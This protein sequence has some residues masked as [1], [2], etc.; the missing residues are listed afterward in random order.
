MMLN[1]F[2]LQTFT[3]IDGLLKTYISGG[4]TA[5]M[6]YVR[7]PLGAAIILYIMILGIMIQTGQVKMNGQNFFKS[8]FKIALIYMFATNWGLFSQFFVDGFTQLAGGVSDAI[9]AANPIKIP[10]IDG[11]NGALQEILIMMYQVGSHLMGEGGITNLSPIFEG[12]G[13]WIV[14]VLFIGFAMFEIILAKVCMA[15]CFVIAPLMFFATLFKFTHGMFDRWLGNLFGFCLLLIMI[16]S[17]LV[18]MTSI[19]YTAM[20]LHEIQLRTT[21]DVLGVF[22]VFILLLIAF[23][24]VLKIHGI[25]MHIGGGVATTGASALVAGMAGF[26]VGKS[27]SV[28]RLAHRGGREMMGG[29]GSVMKSGG[30]AVASGLTAVGGVAGAG[31][32]V[33]KKAASAL[34]KKSQGGE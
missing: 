13:I 25:A 3:E 5:V 1:T 22:P 23:A 29:A 32:A 30:D 7:V 24:F 2:V 28:G 18:L 15:A 21:I 10:G 17:V 8:T 27:A 31:V 26:V 33:A 12:A 16:M 9:L 6:G 11:V 19:I 34:L 14:G 4:Y 20:P